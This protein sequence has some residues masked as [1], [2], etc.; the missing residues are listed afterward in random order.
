[1]GEGARRSTTSGRRGNALSDGRGVG[2]GVTTE[3]VEHPEE[4]SVITT[5]VRP[6]LPRAV[7]G[8]RLAEWLEKGVDGGR[9]TPDEPAT[10]AVVLVPEYLRACPRSVLA[11]LAGTDW[12]GVV[13]AL[14]GYGGRT[15]GRYAIEDAR[16]VLEAAGA[17]VL[18]T[19]LGLDA[20]R[21]RA[22]GVDA[23]DVLL[24]DLLV[25]DL[26][27]AERTSGTPARPTPPG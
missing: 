27:T 14:V 12:T 9:P 6:R 20:A 22:E 19:S 21:I 18:E 8:D 5:V 2:D 4:A 24:R 17:R 13:V 15:R 26:R 3:N 10:A 16:E 1:V 7:L 23:A 25:A 11:D